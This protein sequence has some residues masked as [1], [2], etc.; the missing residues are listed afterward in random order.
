MFEWGLLP[1]H[2]SMAIS[3]QC[4]RTNNPLGYLFWSYEI[5]V[6]LTPKFS[7]WH[8]RKEKYE[9]SFENVFS[10]P[11]KMCYFDENRCINIKRPHEIKYFCIRTTKKNVDWK[12]TEPNSCISF[13]YI[14]KDCFGAFFMLISQNHLIKTN[15]LT[16]NIIVLI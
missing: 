7:I 5:Y 2:K 6:V 10:I 16:K 3:L 14:A 12:I 1:T 15:T 4:F 13:A 8:F 9:N 11:L